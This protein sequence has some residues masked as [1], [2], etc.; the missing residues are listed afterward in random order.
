M[1]IPEVYSPQMLLKLGFWWMWLMERSRDRDLKN[2]DKHTCHWN[3][4]WCMNQNWRE[5]IEQIIMILNNL[6]TNEAYIYIYISESKSFGLWWISHFEGLFNELSGL[7]APNLHSHALTLLHLIII[8]LLQNLQR[9]YLRFQSH[10]Q[11]S[12]THHLFVVLPWILK[13]FDS[14]L[15][16]EIYLYSSPLNEQKNKNKWREIRRRRR[17]GQREGGEINKPCEGVICEKF[18]PLFC[19]SAVQF[20]HRVSRECENGILS[21][22]I[23]VNGN[24]CIQ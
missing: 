1:L 24:E 2:K 21:L 23:F 6:S 15:E 8:R 10:H 12:Q 4:I 3:Y 22:F 19:Y 5:N 14:A 17:K 13:L 11:S 20:L 16:W 9:P 7:P 18:W